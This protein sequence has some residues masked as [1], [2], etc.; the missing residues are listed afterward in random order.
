MRASPETNLCSSSE[1]QSDAG[2]N[3]NFFH[4]ALYILVYTSIDYVLFVSYQILTIAVLALIS[5]LPHSETLYSFPDIRTM[6]F[7]QVVIAK[8]YDAF[9]THMVRLFFGKG[10][11][12][13]GILRYKRACRMF[14]PKSGNQ[15]HAKHSQWRMLSDSC[16]RSIVRLSK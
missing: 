4:V 11:E 9:Q 16:A 1:G 2:M 3:R 15:H 13:R 5:T 7:V 14:I 12:N 8:I 10:E 6:V